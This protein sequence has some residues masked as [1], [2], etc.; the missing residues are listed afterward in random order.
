MSGL[1]FMSAEHV[2]RNGGDVFRGFVLPLPGPVDRP[3]A[4]I[5][6]RPITRSGYVQPR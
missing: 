5:E 6:F 1:V 4:A 2:A 3:I